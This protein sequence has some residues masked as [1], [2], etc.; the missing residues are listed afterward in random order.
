MTIL[1]RQKINIEGKEKKTVKAN[2]EEV[3]RKLIAFSEDFSYREHESLFA[4]LNDKD[5]LEKLTALVK[6]IKSLPLLQW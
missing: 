5:L 3:L 2:L 1:L 6:K 4:F